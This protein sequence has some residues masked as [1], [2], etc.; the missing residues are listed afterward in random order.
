MNMFRR[1]CG[2]ARNERSRNK[3]VRSNLSIIENEDKI[4]GYPSIGFV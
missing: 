1:I 3:C 4:I 2:V